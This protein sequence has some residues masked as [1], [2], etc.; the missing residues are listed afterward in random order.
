MEM[1]WGNEGGN[2]M[3]TMTAW[4]RVVNAME[5]KPVDRIPIFDLIHNI[6]L[7]EYCTGEKVTLENGLDLLCKTISMNLDATRGISPPVEEKVIVHEDG[8]VYKQE[9]WTTWLIER[10]FKD[11]AGLKEY[12]KRN[13][14]EIR[15]Y[16]PGDMWTFAGKGNVWGQSQKSPREQFLELQEKLG[17]TVLFPTESPVGLDTAYI[18]AG[19]DLFVYGY[20]EYPEL[21]SEWLE[22]LNEA[23]IKRVHDTADPTLSPVALVFADMAFK[24]TLLFSPAFLRKEFFPRLKK[25]VD[26]WHSHGIKVIFHSDGNLM[27]VLDDLVATG[28]DGLNP[29]EPLAGM[30]IGTIREKYPKLTLMGG[31]D[32]SQL[33]PY[34]TR[35][36]VGQAVKKAIEDGWRGGGLILGSS[37]E[38]HPDCKLENI[39]QMWESIRNY[40]V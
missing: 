34:G 22:A 6:P 28:I 2:E 13:I 27:E 36:E 38:I 5:F 25:L 11:P 9:W 1:N 23:E 31:I 7:L 20:M 29:I 18:R 24:N 26:A 3:K 39:L 14:D 8:F 10:P 32:C 12:I 30:D 4:E 40:P 19:L 17:D 15:D 16:Q 35:E 37:T 33:L 21:I